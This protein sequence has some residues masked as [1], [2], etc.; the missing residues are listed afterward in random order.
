MI[1]LSDIS[2]CKFYSAHSYVTDFEDAFYKDKGSQRM[3]LTSMDVDTRWSFVTV[4]PQ[5]LGPTA[6]NLVTTATWH[7]GFMQAHAD[8]S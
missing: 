8:V 1:I 5:K 7:P 2:I 6:Q 3:A 4:N